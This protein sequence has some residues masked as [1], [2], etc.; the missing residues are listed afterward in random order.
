MNYY[1][2]KED[3]WHYIYL[4][5]RGNDLEK[6]FSDHGFGKG[7]TIRHFEDVQK[8]LHILALYR[9][10]KDINDTDARKIIANSVFLLFGKQIS[11]P[12]SKSV[13]HA[14]QIKDH[15]DKYYYK[16]ITVEE[17]AGKFYLN[18]N[19]LRTVFVNHI[20]I[21][22]KQYLQKVRMERSAFLLTTTNEDIS[23]IA[24]SVGYEDP[25]LFSKMFKRYYGIS[26]S[27]Y[28]RK[29]GKKQE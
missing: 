29:T 19:Y 11:E 20:G 9:D 28:R 10:I 2:S 6:A 14:E 12:K 17:I 13:Q 25:L 15:I 16:R 23:L 5:L 4:R 18:K 26:P 3:P 27:E 1:P 22:P 7:I 24:N 21:S 8:L